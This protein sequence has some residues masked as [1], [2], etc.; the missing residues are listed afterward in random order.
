MK[1][2]IGIAI[3]VGLV[4]GCRAQPRARPVVPAAEVRVAAAMGAWGA[5][6]ERGDEAGVKAQEDGGGH[7]AFAYLAVKAAASQVDGGA[8][9]VEAT[10]VGTAG[11]WV[12][13]TLWP[14]V[15]GTYP[16]D[17]I[18]LAVPAGRMGPALVAAGIATD[19]GTTAGSFAIVPV[20]KEATWGRIEAAQAAHRARM[21]DRMAWTC[22]PAG[23]VETIAPTEP[24]LQRGAQV[25]ANIFGGWL[26]GTDAIWIVRAGCADGPGLFVI[27]GHVD[28][29][30]TTQDRILAA[31][32]AP[33]AA[34]A[35]N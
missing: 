1:Q 16:E 29:A 13:M 30:G 21:R 26:R 19:A 33:R 8:R 20:S 7:A 24:T 31:V 3:A 6:L 4:A 18:L 28:R 32:L 27:A 22:R 12:L 9:A 5:A 11:L 35:A 23:I 25:S 10:V 15:F 2:R 14:G 34:I 17:E